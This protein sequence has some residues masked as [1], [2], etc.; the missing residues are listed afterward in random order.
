[1]TRIDRCLESVR[2]NIERESLS[3][4]EY[5]NR[6]K[7]R[8]F[9]GGKG[10][11][12]ADHYKDCVIRAFVA[13]TDKSYTEIR[14][15]LNYFIK[16]DPEI[17]KS[18]YSKKFSDLEDDDEKWY[19]GTKEG[20]VSS[21]FYHRS[22]YLLAKRFGFRKINFVDDERIGDYDTWSG[23]KTNDR[24]IPLKGKIV[25][26]GGGHAWAAI[27]GVTYDTTDNRDDFDID[28]YFYKR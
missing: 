13:V 5:K 24:R 3:E 6:F 1:M 28:Y 7:H 19:H 17:Q 4:K 10:K 18:F 11:K 21:G 16:S 25:F 2:K 23:I 26:I 9:D 8:Y 20:D 27:D 22:F 12:F 15:M 14:D